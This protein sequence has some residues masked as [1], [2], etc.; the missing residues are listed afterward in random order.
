MIDQILKFASKPVIKFVGIGFGAIASVVGIKKASDFYEKKSNEEFEK[1]TTEIKN[2]LLGQFIIIDSNIWMMK[3]E[4]EYLLVF[5]FKFCKR[6]GIKVTIPSFQ[7]EEFK[8]PKNKNERYLKKIAKVRIEKY[9]DKGLV[10]IEHCNKKANYVDD[11]LLELMIQKQSNYDKI[12]LITEDRELRIKAKALENLKKD[13]LLVSSI[14]D[15][16]NYS[17]KYL[18]YNNR[19]EV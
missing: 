13:T 11:S 2:K 19:D 7:L 1:I 3:E 18:K 10:K 5:V 16:E 12:S 8:N 14:S 15:L 6:N 9:Q 17:F 4:Y